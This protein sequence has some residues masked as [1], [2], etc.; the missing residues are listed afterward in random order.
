MIVTVTSGSVKADDI[1]WDDP[2]AVPSQIADSRDAIY[3]TSS[4]SD[5]VVTVT[6]NVPA[7]ILGAYFNANTVVTMEAL[8]NKV[9]ITNVNQPNFSFHGG[10]LRTAKT[11]GGSYLTISHN[12][13][14]IRDSSALIASGA[15]GLIIPDNYV[16]SGRYSIATNNN[17]ISVYDSTIVNELAGGFAKIMIALGD[18]EASDNMVY[19]ENSQLGIVY[20]G[21]AI[22]NTDDYGIGI[23]NNNSVYLKNSTAEFVEVGVADGGKITSSVNNV[24]TLEGNVLINQ[25]ATGGVAVSYIGSQFHDLFANNV[26]NAIKPV[27]SGISIGEDLD[28]FEY[29]NFYFSSKAQSG[30]V[31]VKVLGQLTL[32]D[33]NNRGSTVNPINIYNDGQPSEQSI[34]LILFDS[35]NSDI[36]YAYAKLPEDSTQYL[37]T[38][39]NYDVAYTQNPRRLT[40][41]LKN[42][43]LS[44]ET[45]ILPDAPSAGVDLIN[46]G[47]D[48]NT[49]LGGLDPIDGY[50][51][52]D[53]YD[54]WDDFG[55]DDGYDPSDDY[56]PD[57]GY[58]PSDDYGPDDGYDDGSGSGSGD[59]FGSDDGFDPLER[60]RGED[61]SNPLDRENRDEGL[62]LDK[63]YGEKRQEVKNQPYQGQ[64][65]KSRERSDNRR[66]KQAKKTFVNPC[67]RAF[68]KSK[69]GQSKRDNGTDLTLKS[70]SILTGVDCGRRFDNGLLTFGLAFEGGKG[71]YESSR[72]LSSGIVRGAGDLDYSGGALLGRFDFR[73]SGLRRLYLES[74]V[75][76]GRLNSDFRSKDFPGAPGRRISYE[77]NNNYVGFQFGAGNYFR[78]TD[79]SYLNVYAQY[80]WVKLTGG[81]VKLSSGD[82]LKVSDIN[83]RRVRIGTQ[84]RQAISPKW[85][86]FVGTAYEMETDGKTKAKVANMKIP[87]NSKKGGSGLFEVGLAYNSKTI[88]PLSF[89]LAFQATAGR[90]RGAAGVAQ[91]SLVF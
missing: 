81:E 49:D 65:K 50:G 54:P 34:D 31:G 3:P 41:T 22:S 6:V 39:V 48:L 57:D 51:P 7:S 8:R 11:A 61:G 87:E 30:D 85:R 32:N 75:R 78:L 83:S 18:V 79:K 84:Y 67:P 14:V 28:N 44:Q 76:V 19:A 46:E 52:D 80:F 16:S 88:K 77:T 62:A 68:F 74:S 24:L 40:A 70:I 37:G 35:P 66:R 86:A 25:H 60:E 43:R 42:F 55:P 73:P 20:G 23:A 2:S 89:S 69:G 71:S 82:N 63:P 26:F 90:R 59:G 5:N 64:D 12:T 27:T 13:L 33:Q 91:L 17:S 10:Y 47:G 36:D 58:D 38:L 4:Y 15:L 21:H 72:S 53:G 9:E 1:V 45:G 56:G 29:Y